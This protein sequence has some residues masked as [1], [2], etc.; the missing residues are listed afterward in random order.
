MKLHQAHEQL[1]EAEVWL[2]EA[3]SDFE[4]LKE[5]HR[6]ISMQLEEAKAVFEQADTGAKEA[7][8]KATKVYDVVKSIQAE[9]DEEEEEF[10]NHLPETWD[11]EELR[12]QIDTEHAVLDTNFA[13][14]PNA[15]K[16]YEKYQQNITRLESQ[17]E[18]S[19]TT[20]ESYA[21]QIRKA[22][23][24]WEPALD[25]LISTISDAFSYNF[26]QIGCAGEVAV[27]KDDNFDNWS[28]EIKVKFRYAEQ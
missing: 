20:L 19:T 13:S 21:A 23:E 7:K 14:N 4:A 3:T 9:A 15:R 17:I 28:L 12:I 2:L 11:E 24:R 18:E 27:H 6:D 25:E 10:F 8:K 5:R 1:L 16:D 26:Q 22:R